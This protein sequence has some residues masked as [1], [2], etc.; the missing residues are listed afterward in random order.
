MTVK[1]QSG[2]GFVTRPEALTGTGR[3]VRM[4]PIEDDR[5]VSALVARAQR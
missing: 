1:M 3:A 2:D 4:L 5:K